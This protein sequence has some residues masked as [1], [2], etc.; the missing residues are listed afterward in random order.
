MGE[1]NNQEENGM[2]V[3]KDKVS[4]EVNIV[5]RLLLTRWERGYKSTKTRSKLVQKRIHT[6]CKQVF[7][8]GYV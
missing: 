1:G 5:S 4:E 2:G 6:I 8:G 7:K 3:S